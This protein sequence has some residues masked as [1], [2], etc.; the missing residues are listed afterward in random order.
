MY[1]KN[2]ENQDENEKKFSLPPY[3][4]SGGPAQKA[5]PPEELFSARSLKRVVAK[6]R[7]KIPTLHSR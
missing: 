4:T 1:E 3:T 5:N 6:Y 2:N 7:L